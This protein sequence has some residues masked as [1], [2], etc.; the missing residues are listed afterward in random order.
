VSTHVL[1][2]AR[3]RPAAGIAVWLDRRTAEGP[4]AWAP[5][6]EGR[7]DEDGRLR[8]A[9]GVQPGVHRLRFATGPYFQTLAAES[10]YPQVTIVFRVT[11]P[12]QHLHLPLLLSP[13]GYATYRGS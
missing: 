9:Q 6:G 2:T 3:G 5:V 1:D 10:L 8:L 4:E 12:D 11:D 7:T 13:F